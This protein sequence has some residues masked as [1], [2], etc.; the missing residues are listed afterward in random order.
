MG[1]R[2]SRDE[3]PFTFFRTVPFFSRLT[4]CYV[5]PQARI[6]L[7][8]GDKRSFENTRIDLLRRVKMLEFALRMERSVSKTVEHS[9]PYSISFGAS[10]SSKQLNQ[11]VSHISS[12]SKSSAIAGQKD[13][14]GDHK[15][16]SS[17]SSPRSEGDYSM[18]PLFLLLNLPQMFLCPRTTGC[19]FTHCLAFQTVW[20]PPRKPTDN[21]RGQVLQSPVRLVLPWARLFLGETP[22]VE[23][24][25]EI[26]S[27]SRLS[28][29]SFL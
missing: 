15:E 16:E 12:S 27:N 19:P 29:L 22:R 1:N 23:L 28:I 26:I 14:V 8:E 7:L 5:F 4:V 21:T 9:D 18:K 24:A 13:D 3:S 25:V 6:A 10:F 17:G 2:K 11:P 20:V